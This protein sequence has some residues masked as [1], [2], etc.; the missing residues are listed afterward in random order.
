MSAGDDPKIS[1][2]MPSYNAEHLIGQTIQSVIAQSFEGWE[3]VVVD[4]CS[5]DATRDVVESYVGQDRRIRLIKSDINAGGPARPRNIGIRAARAPWI[6]LVDADDIWHP[7]KLERQ[8][9]IVEQSGCE[10]CSTAMLDFVGAAPPPEPPPER[11]EVQEITFFGQKIKGR[12]PTSSVLAKKD[13]LLA[14]P[15]NEDPR[16]KAVEDY[17]C[18]LRV[19]EAIGDSVKVNFPFIFYRRVEG[20]ISG[21]K[22]DMLK[23][24][25]MLHR[26]YPGSTA[27]SAMLFSL[28]HALGGFYFR[29]LK[30]GL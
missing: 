6:A 26:E 12:I 25:Y 23:R 18:W 4:D 17:H 27:V 11:L 19:H 20:Q 13:L 10:F 7:R 24:I 9:A 2:V 21:S 22:W 29:V 30:K 28:T 14:F 5:T 3:L 16:Y 15:F 8:L 1:V